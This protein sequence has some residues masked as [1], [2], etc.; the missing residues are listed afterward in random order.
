MDTILHQTKKIIFNRQKDILSSTII[1]SSMICLSML[2]GL[3]RL[4]VLA[5]YFTKEELDIFLS[6]F[7]IPD[8]IYETIVAG[9]LSS[10]FIPIFVK[11][12][13]DKKELYDNISS[14]INVIF[15]AMTVFIIFMYFSADYL[16]PFITPG[17]T[18]G[19]LHQVIFL[20]KILLLSQLPFF[21]MG[22]ILSAIGQA[23]KIF[24]ASAIAPVLYNI[25]I[26][27]GT[28]VFSMQLG[29][30]GPVAGVF[31]GAFLL[32][33]I[34][35]P[36]LFIT[37]FNYNP[38]ILKRNIIKEFFYLFSP[39]MLTV[40]TRQI[41]LTVDLTLST[42]LGGGSYT[43]FYYAQRIQFFPVSFVGMAFGQASLPYLSE[44]FTQKKIE[45]LKK[46]FVDSVLQLLFISVPLSFLLIYART[47]LV[48]IIAGGKKFDWEATNLTALTLSFFACSIPFHSLFYFVTRAFYAIHNTKIPFIIN[49][50]TTIINISMSLYLVLIAHYPVW[51]LAVAFSVAITI[52]VLISLVLFY[53][54]IKGYDGKRL[55]THALKIYSAAGIASV[56]AYAVLRIFDLLIINSTR[57]LSILMLLALVAVLYLGLYLLLAWLMDIEEL[58]ILSKLTVAL[59]TMKKRVV[60]VYTNTE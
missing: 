57:T 29:I 38:F 37:K 32:F 49:V 9:A 5:T 31:I 60:E 46:I 10:A 4:R 50:T 20:S 48:R 8:F 23:N 45:E 58:S 15:I 6:A 13:A 28:T 1:I 43:I 55:I 12:D 30:G 52:D 39:R 19:Q 27:F 42:L 35:V 36:I 33:L 14:I 21:V 44:L 17:F 25:G 22:G 41:D 51:S 2:F 3:L 56:P 47:P 40:L 53:K 18:Q 7:R 54:E 11:Y 24:L 34:Q 59:D 16:L 26:I